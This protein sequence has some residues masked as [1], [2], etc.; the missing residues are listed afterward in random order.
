MVTTRK[1]SSETKGRYEKPN[2]T[3]NEQE[4]SQA[5]NSS[6]SPLLVSLDLSGG[7]DT[8]QFVDPPTHDFICSVCHGVFKYPVRMYC[9]HVFCKKCILQWLRGHDTCPCCRNVVS[10]RLMI[11][12]H[13]LNRIICR[14]KIKCRNEVHGCRVTFPLSK[15]EEHNVSCEYEMIM[16]P[17][18]DCM[19]EVLRK[20]MTHHVEICPYWKEPCSMG[21]GTV[22]TIYNRDEHNCYLAVKQEW[23]AEKDSYRDMAA[24]LRQKM[25]KMQTMATNLQRQVALICE[26]L[27][28]LD[29]DD[30]NSSSNSSSVDTS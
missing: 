22:L 14:L 16:C 21:C 9:G 12:M 30:E 7:Y 19:A 5:V 8:D 4:S 6:V 25:K 3:E 15:A 20:D 24:K 10:G 18:E 2:R 23:A 28:V 1:K 27:E 13:R 26:S 29:E 17:N 11:A